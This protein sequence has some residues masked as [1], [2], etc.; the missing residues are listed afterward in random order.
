LT[1]L[2][3][4]KVASAANG[5]IPNGFKFYALKMA[6]RYDCTHKWAAGKGLFGTV[7]FFAGLC[8]FRN[9]L[10]G[11]V[12][13]FRQEFVR[14]ENHLSPEHTTFHARSTVGFHPLALEVA[15][16]IGAGPAGHHFAFL[17]LGPIS[18]C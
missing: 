18:S 12:F 2:R 3:G 14:G 4:I 6:D 10:Q 5:F 8:G 9:G 15:G 16:L 13:I 17:D 11:D 1:R 7:S